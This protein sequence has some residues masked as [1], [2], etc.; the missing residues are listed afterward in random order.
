MELLC[1]AFLPTRTN[2]SPSPSRSIQ[3]THALPFSAWKSIDGT[4]S[5]RLCYL[6]REGGN[7]RGMR[8]K[9]ALSRSFE[10]G[11]AGG[12]GQAGMSRHNPDLSPG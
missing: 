5:F 6:G 12:Q 9:C 11:P 4:L 10:P 8:S 1:Q 7:V 3:R 2:V